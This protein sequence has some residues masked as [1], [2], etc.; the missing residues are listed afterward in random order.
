MGLDRFANFISK[1]IN[2]DGIEEININNN[3]RKIISNHIVFDLTFLIY[4]ELIN[5]ENEIND[6]IKIILCL[7][8]ICEN[9]ELL[10]EQLDLILNQPHWKPYYNNINL[11][12]N[13]FNDD[14]IIQQFISFITSKTILSDNT[15]S[16]NNF[17]RV[18]SV[19]NFNRV[20]SVDNFNRVDSVDNVDNI[21]NVDNV[22][23]VDN[24]DN[25]D[26]VDNIDNTDN[27][28]NIDNVDNTDNVD[29]VD[30]VD[31]TECISVI[32]LVIYDKIVNV[33]LD[34]IDKIHDI[35]FIQSLLIFF[36]GIPSLSKI[37]EQRR[38]RINTFLESSE[39]KRIFKLYFDN[40]ETNNKKLCENLSKKYSDNIKPK[41]DT[42]IFDYFKWIKNRFTLDKSIGPSSNF[43]K[44]I[45]SFIKIRMLKHFPKI[46]IY[47][48]SAQEHGESDLKIF[49]YI[50]NEEITGDYCIHTTD[51]DLIHQ[52][53]VQQSYYKIINKDINFT[54]AKYIKKY[55]SVGYIQILEANLIIKN[56]LDLYNSINNIKTINYKIIWDLCLLFY[57]FGNDHLPQ[58]VEIG[59]ELGLE[60]FIKNHYQALNKNN[61]INIKKLYISVDIV[62]LKLVLEKINETK[63]QNIT[64]II[65]Q[66]FF[67]VNINFVNLLVDKLKLNYNLIIIFLKNFIIY[68]SIQLQQMNKQEFDNLDDGDLRKIYNVNIDNP[69]D[70]LNLSIFNFTDIQKKI[71]NDSI[72]LI[73]NNIDYCEIE[74]NGLILYIK[75]II[76]AD[77]PYQDLYN[78][79]VNISNI[80]LN[81]KYSIYN[82]YHDIYS[83]LQIINYLTINT[84]SSSNDY[85]KKMYHLIITQFGNMK[86]FHT[87]NI[88]F[89]SNYNVPSLDNIINFINNIDEENTNTTNTITKIWLKEIKI[90]NIDHKRYFNSINHHLLITPFLFA[91]KLPSEISIIAKEIKNI[92]NLWIDNNNVYNFNYRNIDIHT[93]FKEWD[94]ALIKAKLISKTIKINSE[95]MDLSFDK[96]HPMLSKKIASFSNLDNIQL[97]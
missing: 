13:G 38:R 77:D 68:K 9:I 73:E 64:K 5:I 37:I 30:N 57:F 23:N 47:I 87:N 76:I 11:L 39:K 17:N 3:Y 95:C 49:K 40:L 12:F 19:D 31:N 61:I 28:D 69:D 72:Q 46:N 50:A 34:M 86:N 51:S 29:N 14:E 74:F 33:M 24:I 20:D 36:D 85:L 56:I 63:E 8:F 70:Y 18:D 92:D 4:Q 71:F 91:Y 65:L 52:I 90:E 42:L 15:N 6:I 21:D 44:Q 66:R 27:V 41:T 83:H 1:S 67:K 60:F 80:N 75:S 58:S 96:I 78:Y 84:K 89:Y 97:I 22:D 45:E 35:N 79:V 48:N 25:T 55:N 59:P 88:T 54:V 43:I 81:K 10:E 94:N 93:F 2:N 7:P 16:V 82:N 32:E 26:N 62:N 53:L